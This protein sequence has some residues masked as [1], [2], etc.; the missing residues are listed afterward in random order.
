[1]LPG[2]SDST[3]FRI[4]L[5]KEVQH[6]P[7][8]V[9]P[10]VRLSIDRMPSRIC[11]DVLRCKVRLGG[12]FLG[13]IILPRQR[14]H[15]LGRPAAPIR[16]SRSNLKSAVERLWRRFCFLNLRRDFPPGR[17]LHQ[18]P[19]PRL[20]GGRA[21]L[22]WYSLQRKRPGEADVVGKFLGCQILQP[23]ISLL[24]KLPG[25][26]KA[27]PAL[28]VDVALA[29][30]WRGEEELHPRIRHDRGRKVKSG[31]GLQI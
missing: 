26:R 19:R 31:R 27:L 14:G 21:S 7:H 17:S 25:L 5:K 22:L 15:G 24:R 29:F 30:G 18:E 12:C 4:V 28:N 20:A 13:R 6:A 23:G 2:R 8:S 9:R 3:P 1:M 11:S 10:R 16:S